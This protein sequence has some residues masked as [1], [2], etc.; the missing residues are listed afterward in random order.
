MRSL[1]GLVMA[2]AVLAGVGLG[3]GGCTMPLP[4]VEPAPGSSAGAGGPPGAPVPAASEA[5]A[6][7]DGLTVAR[8]RAMTGYSRDKFPH[9]RK[10]DSNC[11]TRDLVLR[12]DGTDVQ[13]SQSCNVSKGRWVSVYDEKVVT[14][15]DLIDVDHMIPLA[16]AWR[17]GADSWTE[18]QRTEFANDL[19][20]PQL[21]AVSRSSNRAKG[22]QDPSQWKPPNR[23]YW[24]EY[25][26]RWIAVKHHWQ[27]SVTERE[28]SELREMLGS[29]RAQST[30]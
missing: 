18:P 26:R 20:R 22:D 30:S 25:A 16:N 8:A 13:V 7:L 10:V 12:R 27:L 17:S 6:Q 15:P 21:I 28:K 1:A 5:A 29:C 2:A 3:T 9:W 11:D 14:D 19:V 24:C 23:G 4:E